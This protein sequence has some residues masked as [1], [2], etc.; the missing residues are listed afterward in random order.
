[1]KIKVRIMYNMYLDL[2]IIMDLRNSIKKDPAILN[3]FA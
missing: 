2:G 3:Y 1:M